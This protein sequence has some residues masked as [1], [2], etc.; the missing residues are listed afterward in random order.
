MEYCVACGGNILDV[1]ATVDGNCS[2]GIKR[3]LLFGRKVMTNL[4]SVLKNKDIIL[5]TEIHI[6]K[7]IFF[8]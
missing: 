2:H 3:L 7:I 8:Q 4:D 6:A 5:L 1:Y